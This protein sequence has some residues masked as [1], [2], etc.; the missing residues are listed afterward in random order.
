EL[1]ALTHQLDAAT[2]SAQEATLTIRTSSH[3]LAAT[4][5]GLRGDRSLLARHVAFGA[6]IGG[7]VGS[8]SASLAGRAALNAAQHGVG[9]T[10]VLIL[11]LGFALVASIVVAVW[12]LQQ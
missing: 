11:G 1:V 4:A 8:V 3:D 12:L 2:S 7:A 9:S 5:R 6:G 10:V